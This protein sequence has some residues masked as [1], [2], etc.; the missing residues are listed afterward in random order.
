MAE[1]FVV[2]WKPAEA[3][4][5]VERLREAGHQVRLE[6]WHVLRQEPTDA[7]VISLDRSPASGRVVGIYLRQ[8]KRTRHLPLVYLGGP[9]EKVERIRKSLP[10][11]YYAASAD[12]V[13]TVA[14]ALGE[15]QAAVTA[16][17]IPRGMIDYQSPLPKKLSIK[18]GMRVAA[19]G[20]PPEFEEMLGDLPEG[21]R[22]VT[23]LAGADLAIWFVHSAAELEAGLDTFALRTAP[24]RLWVAWPKK[25]IKGASSPARS[26]TQSDLTQNI[27]RDLIAPRG[28]GMAKICSIDATWTAMLLGQKRMPSSA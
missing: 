2:H 6:D 1:I 21:A 23:R 7:V 24:G 12:A 10:D 8:L 25:S 15:G 14:K 3:S 9:P 22:V 28:L 27:V 16:P 18:E 20:A 11:A 26:R 5:L 4:E 13:E 17:V 19:I